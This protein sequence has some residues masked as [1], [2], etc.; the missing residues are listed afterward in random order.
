MAY[1]PPA[2]WPSTLGGIVVEDLVVQYAP[3]LPPVLKGISFAI[4]PREKVGVV[5]ILRAFVALFVSSLTF[6]YYVGRQNWLREK[7]PRPRPA[8]DSRTF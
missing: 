7:Y 4:R 6:I 8:T 1:G 2:A 3:E 5:S